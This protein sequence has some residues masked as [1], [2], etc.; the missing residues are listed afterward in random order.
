M[1]TT[2]LLLGRPGSGKTTAARILM[3]QA[4]EKNLPVVY[5][6]DYE[7]LQEK[8][9][10]DTEHVRFQPL[11]Q[12]RERSGFDVI[13][14]KVLDEALAEAGAR[15]KAYTEIIKG[16]LVIVEFA[17]DNY[18]EALK[19]FQPDFLRE[20]YILFFTIDVET[21]IQRVQQRYLKTGYHLVSEHILRNYYKDQELSRTI[22]HLRST[23]NLRNPVRICDNTGSWENF[24]HQ[25]HHFCGLL[26]EQESSIV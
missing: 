16:G 21:S 26:F 2:I 17:R 5:I 8:F 1:A 18:Q 25:I 14:F 10:A 3:K 15:A 12:D 19:L 11:N 7:L 9:R 20:A 23:Y 4:Q 24:F 22:A 13:D 6:D